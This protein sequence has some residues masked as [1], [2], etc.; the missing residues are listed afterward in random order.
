MPGDPSPGKHAASATA[1]AERSR[2]D[3]AFQ[4]QAPRRPL[5]RY[6]LARAFL[7]LAAYAYSSVEVEG[8]ERIPPGP[9]LYCF[10]HQSWIDPMYV[11]AVLPS[12]PRLY[13]FGPQENDMRRGF[14]NRLMRWFG[15][16]I[17]FA[18]GARGLIAATHRSVDLT[19][20][21]ASIAIAGEGRIHCGE[22]R[23][24][25]LKEGAAY[26][27]LRAGIPLVPMAINGTS[28]LGFRRRIRVRFGDAIEPSQA[29]AD[30]PDGDEVAA[31]TAKAF[32]SLHDLVADFRDRRPPGPA[33]R[34]LTELFNEWPD[35]RRPTS[36]TSPMSPKQG[37]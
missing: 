33:G 2:K 5:R 32:E 12:S 11:M 36:P 23:L 1:A 26:I 37:S 6:L 24:L 17:P 28:W 14:R 21:G 16:V 13:F 20:A 8:R 19:T 10:S 18:P 31:L 34:W 29:T 30:R 25:P 3:A 22:S 27:A 35:G 9:V 15:L 7:K 4:V